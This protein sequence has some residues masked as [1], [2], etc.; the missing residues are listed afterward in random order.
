MTQA[1]AR[2]RSPKKNTRSFVASVSTPFKIEYRPVAASISKRKILRQGNSPFD[3]IGPNYSKA[4]NPMSI[5]PLI[6]ALGTAAWMVI[7]LAAQHS[8][9]PADI[10]DGGKL[11]RTT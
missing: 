9:T 6:L 8:F 3:M 10:E 4:G 2:Q 5:V 11:F 1:R 7:P